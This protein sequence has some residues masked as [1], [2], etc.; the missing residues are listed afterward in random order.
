MIA[1][2]L[3]KAMVVVE[4]FHQLEWT[5]QLSLVVVLQQCYVV[6]NAV[7]TL[8]FPLRQ[9]HLVATSALALVVVSWCPTSCGGGM[10][11]MVALVACMAVVAFITVVKLV[12]FMAVVVRGGPWWLVIVVKVV[13]VRMVKVVTV[14]AV[15]WYLVAE[16][17]RDF[18][19][20][21]WSAAGQGHA[22][23]GGE[24]QGDPH[25]PHRHEG[26]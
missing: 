7:W 6:L 10:V 21:V 22:H 15:W 8:Y 13:I 4:D 11:V 23:H 19:R 26:R 5:A 17:I 20:T 14:V 16:A 2:L 24:E 9:T 1:R 25:D 12:A 3:A 18:R